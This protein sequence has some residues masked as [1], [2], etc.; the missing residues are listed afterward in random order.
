MLIFENKF[1]I[2]FNILRFAT[3]FK[4]LKLS[5]NF[6]YQFSYKKKKMTF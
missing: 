6:F 5:N 2:H 3:F 1:L 4:C